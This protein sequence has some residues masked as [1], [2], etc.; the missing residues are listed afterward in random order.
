MGNWRD[1]E[2]SSEVGDERARSLTGNATS[3]PPLRRFRKMAESMKHVFF[4]KSLMTT[5]LDRA[6]I[7]VKWRSGA[8]VEGDPSSRRTGNSFKGIA[9][10]IINYY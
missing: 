4:E 10:Y 1:D 2:K 7:G 9:C 8:P 6:S 5:K 3:T